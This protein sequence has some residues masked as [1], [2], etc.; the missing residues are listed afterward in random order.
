M[1]LLLDENLSRTLV[2]RLEDIFPEIQHVTSVF[3]EAADDREIWLFARENFYTIVTK[4]NDFEQRSVLYGH[5]PKLIWIRL[6]NCRTLDIERL[7]R[8]SK[9]TI[10][11]FIADEEKSMLPLP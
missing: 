1:K 11:A 5:P 4:D 3:S 10:L 2:K 9:K 6:G 8:D 7:L